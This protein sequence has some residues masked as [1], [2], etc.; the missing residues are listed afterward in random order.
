MK[1]GLSLHIGVNRTDPNRFDSMKTTQLHGCV[2]D[3]VAMCDVASRNGFQVLALLANE[4]AT[5]GLIEA[6][7]RFAADLLG[8]GDTF[9]MTFSGHGAQLPSVDRGDGMYDEG[10]VLYDLT[11]K[12]NY[13]NVLL[14]RFKP[15][16]RVILVADSCYSATIY[17][18]GGKKGLPREPDAEIERAYREHHGPRMLF[19]REATRHWQHNR[20][21][22]EHLDNRFAIEYKR[23]SSDM[24]T[25]IS[26]DVVVLAACQENELAIDGERH[27][28]FTEAMLCL[29]GP[30]GKN[31]PGTYTDLTHEIHFNI[32]NQQRPS[33]ALLGPN[34][35]DQSSQFFQGHVFSL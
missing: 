16:C 18:I 5:L 3:A 11:M 4:F 10:I 14:R 25:D 28:A 1:R 24:S 9:M 20:K 29:L 2:N 32:I 31:F 26:A 15:G 13:I 17:K 33:V 34:A 30:S 23:L 6:H 35:Q 22:Y 7:M 12:D 19:A 27:G 21:R 8:E